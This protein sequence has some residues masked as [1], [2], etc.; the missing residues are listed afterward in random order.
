MPKV[1]ETYF[2][3]KRNAILDAAEEICAAKPLYKLTMKDVIRRTGLSPGAVYASFSDIDEVIIALI[4][5]LSDDVDFVEE[6]D[7]ILR[8]AVLPEE[9]I[10]ALCKYLVKLIY[11]TVDGKGKLYYELATITTDSARTQKLKK[12]IHEMQMYG[13]VQATLVGIVEEY[14]ACGYFT[15]AVALKSVYAFGV[16][17]IDG[18]LRDL[19]LVRCYNAET[20]GGITFEEDDMADSF[21]ASVLF[22]LNKKER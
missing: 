3:K 2:E 15:P 20:P 19:T 22:L 10:T 7:R 4:N 8:D 14:A 16:A 6:T 5:R 11:A 21:A 12:G 17:F 1:D 13:Y 9:K 18:L